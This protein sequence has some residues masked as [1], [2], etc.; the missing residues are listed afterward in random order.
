VLGT[1]P[2]A[3]H[4]LGKCSVTE[5]HPHPMRY[6]PFDKILLKHHLKIYLFYFCGGG[7]GV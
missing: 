1:K 6:F 4:M 3:L 5:L 7:T 2:R